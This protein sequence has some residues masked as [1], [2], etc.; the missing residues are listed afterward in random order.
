M[1]V[2][3]LELELQLVLVTVVDPGDRAESRDLCTVRALANANAYPIYTV[4]GT[5][6]VM[7]ICFLVNLIY[8]ILNIQYN[9]V[10]CFIYCTE[11][12]YSSRGLRT[13]RKHRCQGPTLSR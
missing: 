5:S 6:L 13:V 1:S 2:Y 12:G 4:S 8:N 9:S 10:N 7:S 3:D 11:V